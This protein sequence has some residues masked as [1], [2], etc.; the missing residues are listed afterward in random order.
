MY[1]V[2]AA[3]GLAIVGMGVGAFQRGHAPRP[4]PRED[5]APPRPPQQ[6]EPWTPPRSGLPA[7]LVDAARVLF[8]QG[9][10]DPR[11]CAYRSVELA[12]EAEANRNTFA[13]PTSPTHAWVI[14]FEVTGNRRSA[15]TWNGLVYPVTKLGPAA[16][17]EADVQALVS[18]REA[19]ADEKKGPAP[20]RGF[21]ISGA[22]TG[23]LDRA[24]QRQLTPMM[25]VLLLR[26]GR[27][28]LAEAV[29]KA[30]TGGRPIPLE[31][32]QDESRVLYFR[33][34]SDWAWALL[35]RAATAHTRG[36]DPLALASLREL[37][38]IRPLI[39][40]RAG[41]AP[42]PRAPNP[43]DRAAIVAVVPPRPPG[44]LDLNFLAPLSQLLADQERRARE[45][46]RIT[47]PQTDVADQAARI[48]DSIRA[49]DQ[50]SVG[51]GPI[52]MGRASLAV[53]PAVQ[54]VIKE[55]DAAVGPLLDCLERDDRLTRT[56]DRD[57]RHFSRYLHVQSVDEAAYAALCGILGTREFG[58]ESRFYSGSPDRQKR[59]AVAADIRDYWQKT[60]GLGP[61]ERSFRTLADDEA[62]H[63]QWLDAAE[64][65]VQPNDVRGRGF[66]HVTPY[67]FGGK[68]P[69]PRGEPLRSRANPS[70]TE[71]MA[72]RARELDPPEQAIGSGDLFKANRMAE[73]L[74][75][76]DLK[77]AL[78]TLK[79]RAARCTG[80]LR[81]RTPSIPTDGLEVALVRF[82]M[83]RV[84]GGDPAALGD[85]AAWIRA[86]GPPSHGFFSTQMFEPMWKYPDDPAIAAGSTALFDDPGSPWVPLFRPWEPGWGQGF[87]GG[88][89]VSPLL[90]VAPFRKLVLA[91]LADD[92]ETGWVRCDAAGQVESQAQGSLRSDAAG[93]YEIVREPGNTMRTV[94]HPDDPHRPRPGTSMTVRMRD[95]YADQL[96]E[97]EGFPRFEL[98]W[99]QEL[100][101]R[102]IA[103]VVALLSRYGE[104]F[105]TTEV[106]Q[107]LYEKTPF[108][109]RSYTAVLAFPPLDRP[110]TAAD[111]AAG[112]AIFA[113][114]PGAEA[115]RWTLPA[116]PMEGRWTA[117]QIRPYDRGLQSHWQSSGRPWAQIQHLQGGRVWQAEEVR[118]GDRWR[119]YYGF[120][121]RHVIA[122]VPAEEMDFPAPWNTGWYP[123]SRDLD[124][125]LVAPGGRDDAQR[126]LYA[127]APVGGALPIVVTLRNHRGIAATIPTDL[128][129]TGG[130]PSLREGVSIR[131]LRGPA[132][133][134]EDPVVG[135]TQGAREPAPWPEVSPRREVSRYRSDAARA[136]EPAGTAEALRLDLRDLF[137]LDQ[138]GRY[139]VEITFDD[140]RSEEGGPARISA[141]FGLKAAGDGEAP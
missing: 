120:V 132:P 57:Y 108:Y 13:A 110:A 49:F 105:R 14:P 135:L 51:P 63:D 97:L 6:D 32:G 122:R 41:I 31:R 130:G 121:G 25:A 53:A 1:L 109:P 94:L 117:L 74:A 80:P 134:K 103:E 52:M 129:R 136:L 24:S 118:E 68:V 60:R 93:H 23:H 58:P 101:D 104:R 138:P 137:D 114:A 141:D 79:D 127:P 83:L 59:Q 115:R 106:S 61:L 126:I 55:G 81:M 26:L 36:D 27:A 19:R 66:V 123:I 44:Q 4:S 34:A 88:L 99:P 95:K 77:G 70:I 64:A 128:A 69:P 72:R 67:R 5:A 48:A 9:L 22:S 50:I 113:A 87:R 116:F 124:G 10:A 73:F 91:G 30:W 85:Y 140:I 133:V 54:A 16:D 47:P 38:R 125:R 112:R 65:L 62:T 35:D 40:A 17:F 20:P 21:S 100:R 84:K 18:P 11:G 37:A 89:I 56:V 46:K 2:A 92:R 82:T 12:G 139:R 7:P 29:W 3:A 28:D 45:P 86:I 78:P 33:L 102:T 71:L 39:E 107:M 42:P 90:G 98:Y 75:E 15:V 76:W 8:E 96:Q 119:R 111:V 43:R 131:I